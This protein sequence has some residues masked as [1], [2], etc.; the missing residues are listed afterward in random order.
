MINIFEANKV[1]ISSQQAYLNPYLNF[2]EREEKE[3]I[4]R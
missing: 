1:L 3:D 4:L 2:D